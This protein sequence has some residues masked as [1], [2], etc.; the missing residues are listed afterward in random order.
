MPTGGGK[1][2]CYQLPALLLPQITLV[3]SPLMSLMKDQV[4]AL[5]ANGI[6]AEFVNSSQSRE[7]VL[8][9]FSSLRRGDRKLLYVAPERFLQPQFLERLPVVEVSLLAIGDAHCSTQWVHDFRPD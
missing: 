4:D 9:V 8:Q 1:S 5:Q 2:L 7:Q 3:V 6:A